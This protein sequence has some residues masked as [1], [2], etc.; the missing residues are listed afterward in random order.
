[1]SLKLN[2]F[3]IKFDKPDAELPCIP[4]RRNQHPKDVFPNLYDQE[5]AARVAS[6]GSDCEIVF[7]RGVVPA[8]VHTSRKLY[9]WTTWRTVAKAVIELS[10]ADSLADRFVIERNMIDRHPWGFSGFRRCQQHNYEHL[11]FEDGIA[12]RAIELHDLGAFALVVEWKSRVRFLTTLAHPAMQQVGIGTSVILAET[13]GE[14]EIERFLG[15]YLGRVQ[16]VNGNE[17]T[18]LCRDGIERRIPGNHLRLEPGPRNFARFDR[19]FPKL[20]PSGGIMSAMLRAD[21]SL[22]G[23]MRNRGIF[24]DRLASIIQTLAPNREKILSIPLCF[25]TARRLEIDME[26]V[27]PKLAAEDGALSYF[28]FPQP[29]FI[30]HGGVRWDTPKKIDGL[31]KLGPYK[32]LQK[33][34]PVFGFIFPEKYREDARRLF[35]ALRD[36]IGMFRGLPNWFQV[37]FNKDQVTHISGFDI[38]DSASNEESSKRYAEAVTK[39]INGKPQVIP[40]LFFVVHDKTDSHEEDTPYYVC[41]SLLLQQGILT[42][43]VTVNLLRNPSQFQWSAANIALASFSKLGGTAWTVDPCSKRSSLIIGIGRA[44]KQDPTSRTKKRYQ[45]FTT[46]ISSRGVFGFSYV[47]PEVDTED[48]LTDRLASA[49]VSALQRADKLELQFDSLVIHL[50][51]DLKWEERRAVEQAISNYK[52]ARTPVVC[53]LAVSGDAGI[54]AVSDDNEY[55]MPAR[56]TCVRIS[57]EQYLLFTEGM[58]DLRSAARRTPCS[59][60]VRI[61]HIADGVDP[62]SLVAQVY[63]LSQVNFRA[64]NGASN[65]VS[66]LYSEL[67]ARIL[68]NAKVAS[69][70]EKHPSLNE[71]MWFL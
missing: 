71:R 61:R 22:A 26:P 18:V 53:V 36:G 19:M 38:P 20:A 25:D 21:K 57:T 39:W 54:F 11:S 1:M 65:P 28:S 48:E 29:G 59:V 30:Y 51:G 49:A 69:A 33:H 37:A 66:V 5:L 64:F 58:E 2:L 40:D 55:G 67:I 41:K 68:R 42:Q 3:R 15:R 32:P 63:D 43:N 16:T 24:R 62:T 70:L 12:F 60:Q 52:S 44:E 47:S 4:V 7:L 50:T 31:I 6:R 45:A 17:V 9:E 10:L 14:Q 56:G 35:S 46:C 23:N 13:T 34:K 27:K 8:G